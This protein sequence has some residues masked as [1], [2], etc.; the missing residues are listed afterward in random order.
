MTRRTA[1]TK[2]PASSPRRPKKANRKSIDPVI[3]SRLKETP[4]QQL[5]VGPLV[6]YLADQ[7]WDLEQMIYG[8]AEWFVP[9]T[10]SEQTKR[11]K[12]RSYNGFPVDIAVF[13]SA[14]TVSDPSHLLFLIECKQPD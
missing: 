8:K 14:K 2:K 4:E 12:G 6:Q 7:G 9:K 3:A 13:D 1:R 5:V 10:P 11:E